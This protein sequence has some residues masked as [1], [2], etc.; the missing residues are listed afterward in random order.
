[1]FKFS[2]DSE[3]LKIVESLN[4]D[5]QLQLSCNNF[6]NELRQH[7]VVSTNELTSAERLKK[8]KAFPSPALLSKFAWKVYEEGVD[9]ELPEG[10][11]E[12]TTACNNDFKLNGYYGAAYWHPENHFVVVAHR[13]TELNNV[14]AVVADIAG[15]VFNNCGGQMESACTF[16]EKVVQSMR[17]LEQD[18]QRVHFQLFFTGHRLVVYFFMK[19]LLKKYLFL[20]LAVG[21]LK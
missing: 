12:L 8:I 21:L 19:I 3:S 18:D 7:I 10:W 13:G 16:T 15:I 6:A 5:T 4:V 1:M 9:H 2:F 20:V 11:K 14:G 17:S